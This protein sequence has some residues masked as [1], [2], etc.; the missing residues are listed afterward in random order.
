M[1]NDK[2]KR[3]AFC[4]L[5]AAIIMVATAFLKIPTSIGYFNLGD[6]FIFI[7]ALFLG[8]WAAIAAAIGSALADVIAG[9][10][11]Y[12]P[13]TAVIKAVMAVLVAL[14]LGKTKKTVPLI[15]VMVLAEAVMVLGYFA[16][17][18]VLY[19][20]PAASA[21]LISNSIQGIV[22]VVIGYLGIHAIGSRLDKFR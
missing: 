22:G 16:F 15:I 19:G 2:I 9:F 8:P 21:V 7:S 12:A 11:I 5:F 18:S 13:V 4:G 10:M 1:Q 3:I 20:V 17:E 14:V 6:G